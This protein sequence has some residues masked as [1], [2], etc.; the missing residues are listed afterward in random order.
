[1]SQNKPEDYNRNNFFFYHLHKMK[2]KTCITEG[3]HSKGGD[4]TSQL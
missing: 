4:K 3:R 1:M 2:K